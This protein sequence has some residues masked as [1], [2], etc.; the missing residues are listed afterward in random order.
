MV[1]NFVSAC[2]HAQ[3]YRVPAVPPR[4][5]STGEPQGQSPG[6]AVD[7]VLENRGKSFPL[8]VC[9]RSAFPTSALCCCFQM[10][11]IQTLMK[12]SIS[13]LLRLASASIS[14]WQIEHTYRW[15]TAGPPPNL[16]TGREG[17]QRRTA[18]D[19]KC[20]PALHPTEM[21]F[22]TTDAGEGVVHLQPFSEWRVLPLLNTVR[23]TI[24][25]WDK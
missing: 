19:W 11:P 22:Y 20:F 24:L 9:E 14:T 23:V 10:L 7:R 4:A 21:D 25:L 2:S 8:T 5:A 12:V 3:H 13:I 1:S 17:G 16:S 6:H 15:F 18:G